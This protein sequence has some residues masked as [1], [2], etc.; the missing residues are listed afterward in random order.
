M[1]AWKAMSTA[2]QELRCEGSDSSS[3][4]AQRSVRVHALNLY[5]AFVAGFT[6]VRHQQPAKE[7]GKPGTANSSAAAHRTVHQYW[8]LQ[9]LVDKL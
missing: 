1:A 2:M 3:T 9:T 4:A 6:Y 8:A 7:P 5:A